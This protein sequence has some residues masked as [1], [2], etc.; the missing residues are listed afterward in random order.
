[1]ACLSVIVTSKRQ[2]HY[3]DVEKDFLQSGPNNR[4]VCVRPEAGISPNTAWKL[5]TAAYAL[6]DAA[7][8]W[9][10]RLFN[11]LSEL[12]LKRC[13]TEPAVFYLKGHERNPRGVLITHVDGFL[14][15]GDS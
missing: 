8:K 5:N 3:M 15:A 13:A 11:L 12:G 4:V 9:Y 14:F 1:M 6:T 2:F 7:R 10:S